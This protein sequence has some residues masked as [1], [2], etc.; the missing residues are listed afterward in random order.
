MESPNTRS[1]AGWLQEL[2]ASDRDLLRSFRTYNA[3][4]EP[5]R[6]ESEAHG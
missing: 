5:F 2:G 3:A 4:A 6:E 1:L